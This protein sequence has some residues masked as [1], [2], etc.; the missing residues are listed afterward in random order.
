MLLILLGLLRAEDAAVECEP[1][2][3]G[4]EDEVGAHVIFVT[5][6]VVDRESWSSAETAS[7]L[8]SK[9]IEG[10]A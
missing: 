8:V 9:T 4:L 5:Q 1:A 7:L 6:A 10:P 3:D 2:L